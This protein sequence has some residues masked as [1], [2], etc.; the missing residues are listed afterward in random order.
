MRLRICAVRAS[1]ATAIG[2][3]A[4]TMKCRSP[5]VV[6][7]FQS[8]GVLS[9]GKCAPFSETLG[10]SL[11]EGAGF[12]VLIVV[13]GASE[14]VDLGGLTERLLAAFGAVAIAA[15]AVRVARTRTPAV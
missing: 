9:A 3:I 12:L 2:R 4:G 14:S 11:G 13:V 1:E 7:G 6:A 15:L 5:L 10:T 8:L